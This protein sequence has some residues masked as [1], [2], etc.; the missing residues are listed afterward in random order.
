MP[1]NASAG[2]RTIRPWPSGAASGADRASAHHP[3]A[4][5]TIMLFTIAIVLLVLWALG[6]F[7]G[8]VTGSIIHVLLVIALVVVVLQVLSGRRTV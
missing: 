6:F 2:A 1:E 7:G 3:S 8:F 4:R 5:E